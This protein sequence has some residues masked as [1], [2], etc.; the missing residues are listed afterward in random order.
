MSGGANRRSRFSFLD[1]LRLLEF[2]S[3]QEREAGSSE[4]DD[5]SDDDEQEDVH[6]DCRQM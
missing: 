5:D 2:M 4:N 1:R 3:R 6:P